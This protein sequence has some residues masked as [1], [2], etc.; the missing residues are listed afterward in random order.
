MALKFKPLFLAAPWIVASLGSCAPRTA[1][2][3]ADSTALVPSRPTPAPGGSPG[4]Q[5]I[6]WL[7]SLEK[8]EEQAKKEKKPLLLDFWGPG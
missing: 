6:A 4:R 3:P 7:D 2:P 1:P 8:A 5:A